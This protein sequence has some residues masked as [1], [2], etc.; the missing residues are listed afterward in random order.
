[1]RR[2]WTRKL[3]AGAISAEV[4]RD[5]RKLRR[6][7]EDIERGG[8]QGTRAPKDPMEGLP[9]AT[10]WVKRPEP[11]DRPIAAA[12]A[13]PLASGTSLAPLVSVYHDGQVAEVYHKQSIAPADAANSY[14]LSLDVERFDGTYVSLALGLPVEEIKQ[15]QRSDLI[16]LDLSYS[17]HI[18]V[19][20][21]TRANI[22]IGPNVESVTREIDRTRAKPFVEFDLHYVE[23]DI[24]E[25]TDVWVDVI[26]EQPGKNVI[27]VHDLR[28]SRRPRAHI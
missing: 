3:Q 15:I 28:L 25:I 6:I 11:W 20:A 24:Q 5:A 10:L 18:P 12:D 9:P 7:L 22:K 2:Y 23:L 21:M 4:Q 8:A 26:F 17:S 27:T 14:E 19:N 16:R 1:M 13:S